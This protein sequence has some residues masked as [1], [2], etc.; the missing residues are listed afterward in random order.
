MHTPK[1]QKIDLAQTYPC[2]CPRRRGSLKPIALTDAFGC[3]RCPLLFEL[4][5]DGYRLLQIGG[6]DAY[7]Y[8]WQWI[9]KWQS[10]RERQKYPFLETVMIYG[11]SW[12]FFALILLWALNLKSVLIVPLVILLFTSISLLLWRIVLLRRRDF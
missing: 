8:T 3:D 4:E 2:P 9:G 1:P 5:D 11:L 10:I 7:R 6:L 12:L